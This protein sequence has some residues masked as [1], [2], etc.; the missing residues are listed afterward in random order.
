MKS[1]CDTTVQNATT[2]YHEVNKNIY[3][4]ETISETY[5]L[6]LQCQFGLQFPI[7]VNI[8]L[9][10]ISIKI[11]SSNLNCLFKGLRQVRKLV[12]GDLGL[13]GQIGLGT[14]VFS[15]GGDNFLTF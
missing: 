3:N 5:D 1:G 2:I 4:S 13:Q 9:N 14:F 7:F 15:C 8:F 11:L 6:E 12:S 10:F